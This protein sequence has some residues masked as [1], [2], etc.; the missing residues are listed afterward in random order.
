[1]SDLTMSRPVEEAIDMAE[2]RDVEIRT[3]ANNSLHSPMG[4]AFA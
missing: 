2:L 3:G 1:M 4:A